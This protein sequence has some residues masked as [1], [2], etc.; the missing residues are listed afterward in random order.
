M[1]FG[2]HIIA[3]LQISMQKLLNRLS[4][5]RLAAP[6]KFKTLWAIKHLTVKIQLNNYT[7]RKCFKNTTKKSKS[8]QE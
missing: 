2:C 3:S 6:A 7:Q 8:F 5:A 1:N 4:D